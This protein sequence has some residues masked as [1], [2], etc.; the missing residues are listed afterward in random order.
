MS[1]RV[2][3]AVLVNNFGFAACELDRGI[4]GF[5]IL[6]TIHNSLPLDVQEKL[7]RDGIQKFIHL[8]VNHELY[9][10]RIKES[11]FPIMRFSG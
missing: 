8:Q 9:R 10:P 3:D 6:N 5:T 4:T 11:G 1:A 7:E 2:V